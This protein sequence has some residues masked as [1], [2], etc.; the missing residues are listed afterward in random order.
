MPTWEVYVNRMAGRKAV[1]PA[2]VGGL[3]R[4]IGLEHRL[5][6]PET[7][8]EATSLI[9]ATANGGSRHF[10][11]VGGDGVGGDGVGR[12]GVGGDGSGVTGRG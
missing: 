12:D 2:L 11:V 10:A 9:R 3:L 6:V 5:H 1:D 4:E 7:A 8:E